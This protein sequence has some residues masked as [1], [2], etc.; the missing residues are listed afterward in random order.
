ML[1]TWTQMEHG[2]KPG[3]RI[4]G[5]PEEPQHLCDA[6]QPGAPFIRLEVQELAS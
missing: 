5:Q 1:C 6:A 4:G 3:T 2:N